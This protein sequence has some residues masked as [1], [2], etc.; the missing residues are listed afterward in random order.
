MTLMFVP[1]AWVRAMCKH[2]WVVVHDLRPSKHGEFAVLM[3]KL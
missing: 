1:H 3:E 2:G